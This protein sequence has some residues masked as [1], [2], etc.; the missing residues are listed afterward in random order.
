M[1][2]GMTALTSVSL[3]AV[4]FAVVVLIAARRCGKGWKRSVF[5]SLGASLTVHLVIIASAYATLVAGVFLLGLGGASLLAVF[6]M[7][8]GSYAALGMVEAV[9]GRRMISP[10]RVLALATVGLIPLFT[11]DQRFLDF[12]P[13]E[14]DFGVD[15]CIALMVFAWNA[16]AA[17]CIWFAAEKRVS[18]VDSLQA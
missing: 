17:R 4:C 3:S 7:G 15:A 6:W 10:G 13:Y 16:L 14:I 5:G 18:P 9:T 12:Y 1:V 2:G 11:M 8:L